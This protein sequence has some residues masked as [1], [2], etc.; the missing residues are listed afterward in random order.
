MDNVKDFGAKGDG[1]TDDQNAIQSAINDAQTNHKILFFPSGNY[2]HSNLILFNGVDVQGSGASSVLTATSSTNAAVVLSGSNVS[3][4]NM[5]FSTAGLTGGSGTAAGSTFVVLDGYS[6]TVKNNT[7]VQ[8]ANRIGIVV[9]VSSTGTVNSCICDGTGSANDIGVLVNQSANI[10]VVGNLLQNEAA[11]VYFASG[12]GC[13]SISVLSNSI[14]NVSFPTS[15]YGILALG[16]TTLDIGQNSIQMANASN[17]VPVYLSGCDVFSVSQNNTYGGIAGIAIGAAGA[18]NNTVSQNTIHNCGVQGVLS[19]NIASSA[20][21][22]TS[23]VFG[24][25]GLNATGA[26]LNNAV[27]L[28]EGTAASGATTFVQNNSYQGHTN[29]LQSYVTSTFTSPH[30]PAADVTGN[31]QTQTTLSN[32]I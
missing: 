8:G 11:G 3:I 9:L 18:S 17:G 7:I 5:V 6:F 13:Q 21:A 29:G 15:A 27:I 25:C 2:L 30:I 22:I 26:S 16:V 10:S 19:N 20:L 24:E 31:T 32:H 12:T 23:N 4:Q 28:V 1:I 14:G